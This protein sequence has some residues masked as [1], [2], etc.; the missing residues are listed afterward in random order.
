MKEL[1][2]SL[3]KIGQYERRDQIATDDK[4]NINTDK[5]SAEGVESNVK[6]DDRYHSD[7]S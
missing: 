6:Q 4:E 5:T 7:G 1:E 2:F 3:F